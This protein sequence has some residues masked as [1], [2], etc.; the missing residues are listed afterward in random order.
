MQL[1]RVD[2]VRPGTPGI[3]QDRVAEDPGNVTVF[4]ARM[5]WV[6]PPT[7]LNR[8]EALDR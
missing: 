4:G 8:A 6:G 3:P 1:H 7:G 5:R 2:R